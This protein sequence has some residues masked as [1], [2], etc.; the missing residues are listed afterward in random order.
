[1][2]RGGLS[3]LVLVGLLVAGVGIARADTGV[4]H[5]TWQDNSANEDGFLVERSNGGETPFELIGVVGA[6]SLLPRVGARDSGLVLGARY[7]YRIR[8]YNGAGASDYSETV[9]G[10]AGPPPPVLTLSLNQGVFAPGERMV[11]TAH[12]E[13]GVTPGTVDA[14]IVIVTP[15]G[16]LG[17]LQ[18]GG[19]V[20][21]GLAPI[22]ASQG[23]APFDGEVVS[24]TFTGTELPGEYTWVA[25]LTRPGTLD[26]IGLISIG[27]RFVVYR[28]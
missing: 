4:L 8:A 28:P 13:P 19:R 24:Y 1:M 23:V 26:V 14:Y 3:S 10:I 17:S 18:L 25:A 11:L 7:C 27:P 15:D 20:V 16:A 2:R 12:L 22:A 9:C 21:L 6:N 5:V